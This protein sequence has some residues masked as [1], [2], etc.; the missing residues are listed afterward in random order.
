MN[1]LRTK[2]NIQVEAKRNKA[3]SVLKVA[4]MANFSLINYKVIWVFF[5]YLGH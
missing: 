3:L 1:L 5:V 4:Q 2:L